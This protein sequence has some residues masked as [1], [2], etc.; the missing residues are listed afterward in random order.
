MMNC[1]EGS[2]VGLRLR[3]MSN[4]KT[5]FVILSAAKNLYFYNRRDSSLRYAPFRMTYIHIHSFDLYQVAVKQVI[6]RIVGAVRE[7]PLRW[8]QP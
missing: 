5:I 2:R 7:P 3:P 4:Q 1:L 8:L 6:I